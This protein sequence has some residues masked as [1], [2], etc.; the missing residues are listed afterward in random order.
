MD[1]KRGNTKKRT[2]QEWLQRRGNS[3]QHS[4]KQQQPTPPDVKGRQQQAIGLASSCLLLP[5]IDR[6][7]SHR[8][9]NIWGACHLSL[10]K[11]SNA[12]NSSSSSI[13]NAAA[14][15]KG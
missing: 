6:G 15:Y 1:I 5:T 3:Q 12:S 7:C 11:S 13:D 10:W 9:R 8:K 2:S 4:T 14:P